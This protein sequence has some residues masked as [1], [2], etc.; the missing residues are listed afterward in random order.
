MLKKS[1]FS[2]EEIFDMKRLGLASLLGGSTVALSKYLR[3][4]ALF[5]DKVMSIGSPVI[6][7][8]VPGQEAL[9]STSDFFEKTRK[10]RFKGKAKKLQTFKPSQDLAE[11]PDKDTEKKSS[12]GDVKTAFSLKSLT[13]PYYLPAI[14]ASAAG[15]AI[16]SNMLLNYVLKNKIKE[17]YLTELEEAKK[18]FGEALI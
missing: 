2:P 11:A 5:R 6:E 16:G 7:V 3:P 9:P 1:L 10:K 18:E 14:V 12:Y 17:D 4:G 15:P 13:N 8:P